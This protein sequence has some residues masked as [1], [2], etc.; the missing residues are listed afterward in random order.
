MNKITYL[1]GL[2]GL[3]SFIV[4][5][6]HCTNVF[7][8]EIR[9]TGISIARDFI[10]WSPLNII[11][12]GL[13]SVY[14]FFIL[15]GF[16]LSNKYNKTQD[17][18]VLISGSIKR[19]PRL[20]SPIFFS[21]IIMWLLSSLASGIFEVKSELSFYDAILQA[22]VYVPF[23]GGKLTNNVLWTI[24]FEL[25]GSFLV[26]SSLAIFGRYKYKYPVYLLIFIMTI[27]SYYCLFVFG[28][29]LN[30]L[31]N[32]N[33]KFTLNN[34]LISVVVFLISLIFMAF[35]V[36]RNGVSIGGIYSHLIFFNDIT[37]NRQILSKIGAMLLF[38]SMFNLRSA[39]LIL[40]KKAFQFM[41]SVSFSVYILHLPVLLFIEHFSNYFEYGF[42]RYIIMSLAVYV[43]TI[44]L[45]YFF[46]KYID[47]KSVAITNIIAKNLVQ[48]NSSR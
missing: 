20:I 12:S 13:P 43:C 25:Y 27:N 22:F 38:W 29:F 33:I 1:E 3:C 16:V 9:H 34:S 31:Y 8:P 28:M 18:N 42:K 4:I 21:M 39:E 26:F 41:G 30:S 44:A 35:P 2:R 17:I 14:I 45:S 32:D 24:T 5:F 6:D 23:G 47:K 15:S 40:N 37:Y 48:N 7:Y 10:A 19:Y 11:Y 46:E 36:L